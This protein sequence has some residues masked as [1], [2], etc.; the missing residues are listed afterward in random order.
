VFER[1]L[2]AIPLSIDLW[3]HHLKDCRD[4]HAANETFVREQFERAM[5]VWTG[6]LLRSSLK[7]CLFSRPFSFCLS[8][9][10]IAIKFGGEFSFFLP[11]LH[12]F[13][14]LRHKANRY[15]IL[16]SQFIEI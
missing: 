3:L 2:V 5:T 13:L 11:V 7:A 14:P 12:K 4:H 10:T 9:I 6:I 1:G 15:L 8:T 16:G